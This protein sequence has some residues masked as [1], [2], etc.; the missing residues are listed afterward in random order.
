MEQG[1]THNEAYEAFCVVSS[2]AFMDPSKSG[3][4]FVVLAEAQE[5][6]WCLTKTRYQTREPMV[7]S[8]SA[9]ADVTL[10]LT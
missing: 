1:N 2:G 4:T 7:Y 8:F 3:F 6:V 9:E 5:F 10:R